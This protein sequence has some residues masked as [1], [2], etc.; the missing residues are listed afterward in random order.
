[1]KGTGIDMNLLI[2][3]DEISAI[4]AV[5]LGVNWDRLPYE[6]RYVAQSMPEAI[7]QIG[8]HSVDVLLCDI[9]MPQG[10]GLDLLKWIN[11][12]KP[13]ICCIFMT[14]HA[15]FTFAQK[16]L[17]LGS[18]EYILKPLDMEHL[19]EVLRRGAEKV[20]A[21]RQ[22][23]QASSY[24]ESGKRALEKQFWHAL[25]LGEVSVEKQGINMYLKRAQLDISL[26]GKFLSMLVSPG[27]F[28]EILGSSDRKLFGFALRNVAEE[29]LQ[30]L[31]LH[32]EL[33][34]LSEEKLLVV[35]TLQSSEEEE[36]L[37]KLLP[38]CGRRLIE[39]SDRFLNMPICCLAGE[40]VSLYEIPEQMER[41]MVADI[42]NVF[43]YKEFLYAE[44]SMPLAETFLYEEFI[45]DRFLKYQGDYAKIIGEIR[46]TLAEYRRQLKLDEDFLK[47]FYMGI[48]YMLKGF[49]DNHGIFL[50]N[51]INL[52][53]NRSLLVK[54]GD[55]PEDLL[56]WLD[57]ILEII[58][59]YEW[60]EAGPPHTIEQV[61][62]YVEKHLGDELH[63]EKLAEQVHL[64]A[65]YLNRIF[66]KETG[67][68]ISRYVIQRKMERAKWLLHHTDWTLVEVAAAVGY[69]NYSS[70][71][72]SFTKT[73]GM[74][75]QKWKSKQP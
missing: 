31:P 20:K 37:G 4:E 16:A 34:P 52:K 72:R 49:A 46:Q 74:T 39:A 12:N 65:D 18:L 45:T 1:V 69:Y 53:K 42:N 38:E 35:V 7:A 47:Q 29:I 62:G 71:T 55:S 44:R 60:D 33:M 28:S 48:Y 30:E 56:A 68:S 6:N 58:Q 10:T 64:N 3:D 57:Y 8:Q 40:V 17:S 2:V 26:D 5:Q 36:I 67:I 50:S 66:K 61:K 32:H 21:D 23:N 75:P 70:F 54:T 51:V 13:G 22:R 11:E 9:E 15:D 25:F 43:F 73:T 14:C 59:A 27:Q 63:V 24:L 41:L 19:E